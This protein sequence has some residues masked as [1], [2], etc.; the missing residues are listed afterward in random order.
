[1]ERHTC[2]A[3]KSP[4]LCV[5]TSAH[6]HPFFVNELVLSLP[7]GRLPGPVVP[8]RRADRLREHVVLIQRPTSLPTR[9][10]PFSFHAISRTIPARCTLQYFFRFGY[11]LSGAIT[12]SYGVVL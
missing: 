8:L 5:Q 11:H 4:R 6:T 9:D 12:R 2:Q 10:D 1:M 7:L 3:G